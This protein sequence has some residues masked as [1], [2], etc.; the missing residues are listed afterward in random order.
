MARA[1]HAGG[2]VFRRGEAGLLYLLV[3]SSGSR[4]RFVLPK[5]HIERRESAE[6]AALREVT[7]EAA[8]EARACHALG[9]ARLAKGGER[10]VVE[11]FLMEYVRDARAVEAR[12]VR[13]CQL[14]QAVAALDDDEAIRVLERAHELASA[15]LLV[16]RRFEAAA[17]AARACA[18]AGAGLLPLAIAA[19]CLTPELGSWRGSS[20]LAL[21]GA[22]A[23]ALAL[24]YPLGRLLI[25]CAASML[26]GFARL[27]GRRGSRSQP[28]SRGAGGRSGR[29]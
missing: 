27:A 1:T 29:R 22:G 5:G 19:A 11:F 9:R 25:R 24:S 15:A 23:A 3:A 16:A 13:W 17:R 28:R 21:L 4:E 12:T 8:V 10:I 18:T 2:V 14:E 7:E 20:P 6:Q 26:G